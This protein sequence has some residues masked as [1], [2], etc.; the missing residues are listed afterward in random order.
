MLRLPRMFLSIE[1]RNYGL[2]FYGQLVSSLGSW[3]PSVLQAWLVNRLTVFLVP[4]GAGSFYPASAAA[5]PLS[6]RWPTEV[7]LRNPL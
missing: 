7:S 1:N 5:V 6:Y 3:L 2:Y 4:V